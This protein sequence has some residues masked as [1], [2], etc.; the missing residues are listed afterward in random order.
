MEEKIHFLCRCCE[1]ISDEEEKM[2]QEKGNWQLLLKNL[3]R[4]YQEHL[5]CAV[6]V[7]TW[8][9]LARE[10]WLSAKLRST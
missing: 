7:K 6:I 10:S 3:R 5:V 4:I 9:R 2:V 1:K 8:T